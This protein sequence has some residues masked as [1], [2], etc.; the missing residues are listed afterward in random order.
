[1]KKDIVNNYISLIYQ[2]VTV[3]V[4]NEELVSIKEIDSNEYDH[5]IIVLVS[6]DDMARLIG[7]KGINANSIRNILNAY[8]YKNNE[9]INIEFDSF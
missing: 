9:K 3:F 5:N 7:Y 4:N 8:A 1:M 6:K 2:L